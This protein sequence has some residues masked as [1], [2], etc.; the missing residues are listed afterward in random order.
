MRHMKSGRKFG[1]D[2]SARKAMFRSLVGNLFL[3]ERIETTE[4]KA[5]ELRRIAD[6]LITKA[7]RLGGDLTK[8]VSKMRGAKKQTAVAKRVHAQR[9]VAEFL[10]RK[11]DRT[12]PGGETESVDMVN[13]LFTKIAPRYIER[14]LADKGGGYT[15]IIK[16]GPR[17]GDNAPMVYIELVGYEPP[18]AKAPEEEPEEVAEAAE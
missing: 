10:P 3:H 15:R 16:I 1:R 2:P 12:L 17:R 14:V 7:T 18:T 8:D 5:K 11:L 4:A 13:K 6:R 9:L